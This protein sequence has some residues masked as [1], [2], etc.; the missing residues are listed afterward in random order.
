MQ[1]IR[2]KKKRESCKILHC[3]FLE[4]HFHNHFN[5]V[6]TGKTGNSIKTE[7]KI[8]ASKAEACNTCDKYR[9]E[10]RYR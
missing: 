7:G 3:Q 10:A 8:K 9:H 1:R 5:V 6:A 4:M 2:I